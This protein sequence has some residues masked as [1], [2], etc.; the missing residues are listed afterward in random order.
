MPVPLSP[1]GAAML[2][3]PLSVLLPWNLLT[4]ADVP[5]PLANDRAL[6]TLHLPVASGTWFVAQGGD[7]PNVNGHM[8]EPAQ[9]FA[10]DLMRT[11]DRGLIKG[12]GRALQDWY[13]F[14]EPV[15]APCAGV[16]TAAVGTFPDL[17]VGTKDTLHPFG[18]HVIID[19]GQHEWVVLAHLQ[20]G[21]VHVQV[22]Q[23]LALGQPLGKVGNSGSTDGPCLELSIQDQPALGSGHGRLFE[24]TACTAVIAGRVLR[25]DPVPLLAGEWLTPAAPT[26][27]AVP[28]P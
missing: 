2:L 18:N 27:G 15:V 26:P 13:G 12:E 19:D 4:G 23:H 1:V 3:V 8:Q 10:V 7:T 21:S 14:G 11:V 20:Q 16:V 22:G 24:V 6:V 9:A 5:D 25:N 28:H 17:P